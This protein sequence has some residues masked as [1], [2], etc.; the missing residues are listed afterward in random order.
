MDVAEVYSPARVTKVAH[1]MGLEAGEAFDLTNGW[2]FRLERHRKAAMEY[3]R[4]VKPKL[5]IWE[6]RM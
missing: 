2:D 3:I 4:R 6:P 1:K 5:V